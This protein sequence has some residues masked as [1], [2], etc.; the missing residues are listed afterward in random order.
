MVERL[1]AMARAAVRESRENARRAQQQEKQDTQEK[2]GPRRDSHAASARLQSRRPP[3][4]DEISEWAIVAAAFGESEPAPLKRRRLSPT[5]PLPSQLPRPSLSLRQRQ[6]RPPS[7][8]PEA[9]AET[10]PFETL[11]PPQRPPEG[12][13]ANSSEPEAAAAESAAPPTEGAPARR[14]QARGEERAARLLPPGWFR[15]T[16]QMM[17]LVGC[18]E[19]EMA[20]ELRGLGYRVHPP[21]EENG[22]RNALEGR[23]RFVREREEQSNT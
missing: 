20:N 16:P 12:E 2:S 1:A 23:P 4:A 11:L 19:P 6:S 17:S 8:W 3:T 14:E 13:T 18:S 15:A 5:P 22:Q 9:V 21:S 10:L 7:L